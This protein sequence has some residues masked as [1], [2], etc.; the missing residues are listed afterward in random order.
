MCLKIVIYSSKLMPDWL[1]SA[2]Q[3]QTC[4]NSAVYLDKMEA[5][6]LGR[7]LSM[8]VDLLQRYKMAE[9]LSVL[10]EYTDILH[11]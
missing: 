5:E 2:K 10:L 3:M 7:K 6:S 8:R 4:L 1:I 9:C 11:L